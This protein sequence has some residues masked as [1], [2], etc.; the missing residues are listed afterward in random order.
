MPD[1]SIILPVYNAVSYLEECINSVLRQTFQN[2]ELLVLDDGSTDGSVSIVKSFN[3]ARIR[4]ILCEHNFINTLNLGINECNGK[5][6]AR[7]D[8]DDIMHE[9]RLKRQY[10]IMEANQDVAVCGTY[11]EAFGLANGIIGYGNNYIDSPLLSLLPHNYIIHPSVMIRKSFIH[12]NNI[13]Y[14]NYPYAEDYK[15]WE[16]IAKADGKFYVI[17]EPLL[18]YRISQ[19]QV[20]NLNSATQIETALAIQTEILEILL[21]KNTYK[22]EWVDNLYYTMLEANN[23]DLIDGPHIIKTFYNMLTAIKNKC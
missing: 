14:Q 10:E 6:I 13:R 17:P 5:Y 7:M 8:A 12:N 20:S 4:I 21:K 11:A 16:D 19:G 2:Y 22:K 23:D 9:D 1:I 18:K 15:M 3:D